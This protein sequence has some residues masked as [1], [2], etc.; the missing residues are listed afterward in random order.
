MWLL[1]LMICQFMHSPSKQARHEISDDHDSDD[2]DFKDEFWYKRLSTPAS[3][4]VR[5]GRVYNGRTK[6]SSH[7]EKR[8]MQSTLDSLVE[9][10]DGD[11]VGED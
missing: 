4:H 6:R 8:M 10:D 3:L 7:H 1:A 9:T 11:N 2:N 5:S